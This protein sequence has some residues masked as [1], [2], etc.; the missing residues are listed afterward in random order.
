MQIQLD[1]ACPGST[2]RAWAE[3]AFLLPT[4]IS[5]TQPVQIEIKANLYSLVPASVPGSTGRAED[6]LLLT[7]QDESGANLTRPIIVTDGGQAE[8]NVFHRFERDLAPL[9]EPDVLSH[10]GETL[11]FRLYADNTDGRGASRFHLDQIRCDVCTTVLAPEPEPDRVY[12]VG[13]RLLVV[14]EGRPTPMPGI[15]VWAIQLPDGVTPPEELETW[16]TYSIQDSTYSMFN[17]N[18]GR[19]RIYAEA[20]VSGNLYSATTTIEVKAG[21][22]RVDVNLNLL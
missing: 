3:Q 15:D 8:R 2:C 5:S 21:D 22:I 17:L 11:R 18:P 12:R 13:G 19:Y 9:M 20:W 1:D 6:E 10:F 7:I 16:S 4:V 14:L